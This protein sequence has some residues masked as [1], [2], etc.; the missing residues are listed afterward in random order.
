M[1]MLQKSFQFSVKAVDDE[2]GLVEAYGSVFDVIDEGD[3]YLKDVVRSGAFKRTIKNSKAKITAGKA[4][5]LATMLWSHDPQNHLPI[6][7]WTDLKEDANGLL[8]KGQIVLATQ[9]GREV[10][11]LIKAGVINQFSIGYDIPEGGS[12]TDFKSGVRELTEI[13]LWEI[14]PVVFAM[15]QEALLVSVKS[16]ESKSVC[17]NTSGPIGPRD[18][19]WDG[20]AAKKWIWGKALDDEGKVKSAIA[21]KYFM[22]C[23]GD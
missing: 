5:F 21:K 23:D 16:L 19:S 13:R 9:L 20:S 10:Y 12:T 7:G 2:Q 6:G 18:E 15:N 11:E 17:G 4:K 22:R 14:S 3:G 1:T 8:G